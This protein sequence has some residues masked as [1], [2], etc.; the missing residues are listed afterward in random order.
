MFNC[1]LSKLREELVHDLLTSL[2]QQACKKQ[3][4]SL[5]LSAIYVILT[6]DRILLICKTFI[7]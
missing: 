6:L 3:T 7:H 1:R 5:T 4:S 2:K